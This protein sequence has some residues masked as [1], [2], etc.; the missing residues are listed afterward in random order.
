MKIRNLKHQIIYKEPF[1]YCAHP[2]IVAL[3]N[4]DWLVVFNHTIRRPFILHPPEDPHYY[5]FMIRSQDQGKSWGA[6]RVVPAYDW[7]GV[8]CAGLTPLRNGTVLLNQWQFKWYPRELAKALASQMELMFVEDWLERIK[9]TGELETGT[10]I[11]DNPGEIAPWARGNGGTY[12]H[13][14]TD[15]GATFQQTVEIDTHPYT[16]GYGMRPGVELPDGD[17][18]LPLSDVPQYETVF[19]VRSSDGGHSWG[20]PVEAARLAGHYFEEPTILALADGKV[21]M[22][23]RDNN[24]HFLYQTMSYD[25]GFT[26]T[27]AQQTAIW[28]YPAHLLALPGGKIAC[29]YGYRAEPYGIRLVLSHD[30]G[31]TWDTG[32]I[33]EIRNDLPNRDLGYPSAI[34][35]PDG[36]IVCVY[37]GQDADGVTCIQSSQFFLEE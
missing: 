31:E 3:P 28:G 18:L 4:G 8:E 2:L 32:N 24:T 7:H 9:L 1:A 15:G 13:L 17:I 33:M 11:P 12:V 26:W 23:L 35:A 27:P 30:L 6:P 19:V 37:Y 20:K 29:I 34:L 16:G 22:M 10:V 14:S 21:L 36:S 5:N 25:N